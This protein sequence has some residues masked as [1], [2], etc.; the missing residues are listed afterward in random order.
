M[1][2]SEVVSDLFP[3]G[4]FLVV[5]LEIDPNIL[6]INNLIA[7]ILNISYLNPKIKYHLNYR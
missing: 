3:V 4:I 1:F 5:W 2:G 6:I 7:G